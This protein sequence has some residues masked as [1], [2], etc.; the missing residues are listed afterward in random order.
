VDT[1]PINSNE[2]L[3]EN[4]RSFILQDERKA[5]LEQLLA[6]TRHAS[7]EQLR[8]WFSSAHDLSSHVTAMVFLGMWATQEIL[9]CLLDHV[10]ESSPVA[11]AVEYLASK[12]PQALDWITQCCDDLLQQLQGEHVNDARGKYF[13]QFLAGVFTEQA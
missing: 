11:F 13:M 8:R 1:S 7:P 3:E 5:N 10:H 4:T 6:M 9:P 12:Q 2:L